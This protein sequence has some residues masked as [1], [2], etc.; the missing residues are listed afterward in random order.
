M[1]TKLL[2]SRKLDENATKRTGEQSLSNKIMSN[3]IKPIVGILL[4]GQHWIQI[5]KIDLRRLILRDQ[6][7]QWC[8]VSD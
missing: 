7:N 4:P 5:C 2:V 1:N 8:S 6:K 3:T